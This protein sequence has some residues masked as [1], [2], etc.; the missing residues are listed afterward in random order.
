MGVMQRI[1]RKRVR[2]SFG[3]QALDYESHASVQKRVLAGFLDFLKRERVSPRRL[4]D[5]GSGTGLLLRLLREVYHDACAVGIDLAPG[6]S[7]KAREELGTDLRTHILTADAEHLPF[8]GS[9]FDL[10]VSTSA[11]QWLNEL[12]VAFGEACRVLSPGGLFCFA[13]FGEKTLYELRHSFRQAVAEKGRVG[14]DRTHSFFSRKD[15]EASL[16]RCGFTACHVDGHLELDM[17]ND[18]AALLRS[19]KRIG[20]GN[21]SPAAPRGLVGKRIMTDMADIYREAYGSDAG[22]P[23]TYEIIYG[24]GK[25][26][27]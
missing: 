24:I 1:D 14:E 16:Y 18:V 9:S 25:K 11:F 23:A 22:I 13:L 12:D 4:L 15:V 5:V 10:V 8:P 3:R 21:A 2:A 7:R 27:A 26:S 6:M 20:A 19:L 17:H